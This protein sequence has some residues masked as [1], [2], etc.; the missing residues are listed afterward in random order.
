MPHYTDQSLFPSVSVTV[1]QTLSFSLER[2][3][4]LSSPRSQVLLFL[5]AKEEEELPSSQ[6]KARP[7]FLANLEHPGG[8]FETRTSAAEPVRTRAA[9][10]AARDVLKEEVLRFSPSN[11]YGICF[12][13]YTSQQNLPSPSLQ[14][15]FFVFEEQV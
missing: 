9:G 4:D 2:G 14:I 13:F 7:S 15:A 8:R 11:M 1:I 3:F 12:S 10:P 6:M 5:Q